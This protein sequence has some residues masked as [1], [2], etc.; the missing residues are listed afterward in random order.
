MEPLVASRVTSTMATKPLLPEVVAERAKA[1]DDY[2]KA[3]QAAID[4]IE[5]LRAAR[6]ER[7]AALET[8]QA[9]SAPRKKTA[10]KRASTAGE[11]RTKTSTARASA[12]PSA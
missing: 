3:H 9:E 2:R 5:K 11:K 12:H 8:V 4:R 6:M 10:T 1:A 7:D